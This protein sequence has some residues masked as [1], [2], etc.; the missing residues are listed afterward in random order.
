MGKQNDSLGN[1]MKEYES[2]SRHFLTRRIPAI[3]RE[4]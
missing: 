1:R 2:V 4:V 3:I